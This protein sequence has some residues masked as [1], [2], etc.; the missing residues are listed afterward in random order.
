MASES[1]PVSPFIQF[2]FA[3]LR[4]TAWKLKSLKQ[5]VFVG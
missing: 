5:D 1:M 4:A 3:M 2:N